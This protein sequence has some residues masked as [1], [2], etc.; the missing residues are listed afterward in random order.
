[1]Q[2]TIDTNKDSPEEIQKAINLLSSLVS[3]KATHSNIF[4]NSSPASEQGSVFANMF[5]DDSKQ[6]SPVLQSAPV[7]EEIKEEEKKD[8]PA[9]VEYL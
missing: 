1:M 5:G 9:V 6:S 3:G 7:A 4:E 8:I 2:I